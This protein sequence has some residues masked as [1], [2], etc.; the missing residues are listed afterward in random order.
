MIEK[1]VYYQLLQHLTDNDLLFKNQSGYRKHN[2]CETAITKMYNDL[3]AEPRK[4]CHG[5][6]IFL[7]MSAVFDTLKHAQLI[8]ELVEEYAIELEFAVRMLSDA[9]LVH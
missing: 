2:S 1:C 9:L 7:D 4:S 6:L 3:I 5:L 8:K